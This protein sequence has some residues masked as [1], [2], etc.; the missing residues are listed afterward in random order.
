ME[1]QLRKRD[2]VARKVVGERRQPR[3]IVIESFTI[4]EQDMQWL[5]FTPIELGEYAVVI[6]HARM[7]ARA[8]RADELEKVGA[9]PR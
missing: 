3:G 6:W 2:I 8:E 4:S 5:G 1:E 7:N 9:L